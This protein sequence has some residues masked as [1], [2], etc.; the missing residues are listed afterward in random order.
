MTSILPSVKVNGNS[1]TL[2][3]KQNGVRR[4]RTIANCPHQVAIDMKVIKQI[5]TETFYDI[6]QEKQRYRQ[7]RIQLRLAHTYEQVK[8]FDLLA[9]LFA[10][11]TI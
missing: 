7:L 5:L 11:L 9:E 10:K 6:H 3:Y 4:Q 1:I 2:T 8:V